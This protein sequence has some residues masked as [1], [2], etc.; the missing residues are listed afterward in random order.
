MK[1]NRHQSSLVKSKLQLNNSFIKLLIG[2]LII[3]I[4]WQYN[5]ITANILSSKE[6]GTISLKKVRNI[7]SKKKMSHPQ[8]IIFFKKINYGNVRNS[9]NVS[10]NLNLVNIKNTAL[11]EGER[12]MLQVFTWSATRIIQLDTGKKFKSETIHFFLRF[13]HTRTKISHFN[14]H[15]NW[16]GY[17][18]YPIGFRNNNI[19]HKSAEYECWSKLLHCS[20]LKGTANTLFMNLSIQIRAR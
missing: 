14:H 13:S 3:M 7:I 20:L 19:T 5:L 1:L 8:L 15:G 9:Q 17:A 11:Q 12:E 10:K 2:I 18:S 4:I 6:D 16:G